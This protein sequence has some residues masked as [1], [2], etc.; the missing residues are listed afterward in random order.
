VTRA[1][2]DQRRLPGLVAA[3]LTERVSRLSP[4]T[5]GD[6]IS[7]VDPRFIVPSGLGYAQGSNTTYSGGSV[8]MD[9]AYPQ[10][11]VGSGGSYHDPLGEEFDHQEQMERLAKR[12]ASGKPGPPPPLIQSGDGTVREMGGQSESEQVKEDGPDPAKSS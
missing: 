3:W 11:A 6:T 5:S 10:T 9:S 12:L 1:F 4:P 8:T 7:A 2:T